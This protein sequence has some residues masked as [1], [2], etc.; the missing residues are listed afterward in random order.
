MCV[1]VDKEQV[2]AGFINTHKD[3]MKFNIDDINRYI[4]SLWNCGCGPVRLNFVREELLYY[5]DLCE[6]VCLRKTADGYIIDKSFLS[7]EMTEKEK[8]FF[9]ND[10]DLAKSFDLFCRLQVDIRTPRFL[11]DAMGYRFIYAERT[12]I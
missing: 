3:G 1:A 4:L 8:K 5:L 7:D 6:G 9:Y 12:V 2:V 11:L 10:K